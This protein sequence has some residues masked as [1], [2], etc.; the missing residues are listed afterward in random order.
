MNYT[1]KYDSVH[2]EYSQS[3]SLLNMR[4]DLTVTVMVSRWVEL[5]VTVMVTGGLI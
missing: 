1:A 5:T 2:L 4:V 3:V